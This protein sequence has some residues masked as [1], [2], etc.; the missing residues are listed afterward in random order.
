MSTTTANE[1]FVTRVLDAP[2]QQVWQAWT[3]REQLQQWWGPKGLEV[4]IADLDLSPGGRCLYVM[5]TAEGSEMWG[6]FLYQEIEAPHKLVWLN[7]FSTAEGGVSR[8]PAA[9]NWPLQMRCCVEFSEQGK[10]TLLTL[11]SRAFEASELEE[12]TFVEGFDSMRQ[13]F[14]GTFDQ[15]V[16]YLAKSARA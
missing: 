15:L 7:A 12:K 10:Q 5:R 6:R 8:H 13:G 9:A 4:E 11:R 16:D 2:L 14:G 1:F 3:E